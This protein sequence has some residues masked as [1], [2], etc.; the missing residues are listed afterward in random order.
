[1]A[2]RSQERGKARPACPTLPLSLSIVKSFKAQREGDLFK[3]QREKEAAQKH[4]LSLLALEKH[5]G[6]VGWRMRGGLKAGRLGQEGGSEEEPEGGGQ[7]GI[8]D[9]GSGAG[10]VGGKEE[11]GEG[12]L[13]PVPE[14]VFT[15]TEGP[16]APRRPSTCRY[17]I[18][19]C[20]RP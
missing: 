8:E 18:N 12:C 16:P 19:I 3:S 14:P 13:S 1:M 17:L 15:F 10:G 4:C 11:M 9:E 7:V 5:R 20:F 2:R 6:W